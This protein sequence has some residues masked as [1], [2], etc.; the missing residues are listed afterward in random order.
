MPRSHVP[1]RRN[2]VARAARYQDYKPFLREDFNFSCGYCA[3][4]DRFCGGA[5][6]FH[7]DHF[8]P[9][10]P[11]DQ[12]L[13]EYS[14][15]VYSCPFC[16]GGKSN[17][18]IGDDPHV[19]HNGVEGFVDPCSAEFDLHLDRTGDGRFIAL[20]PVGSYMLRHLRL[21]LERH[22]MLWSI[23][24]LELIKRRGREAIR[25]LGRD[26]PRRTPLL[27]Q[28]WEVTNEIDDYLDAVFGAPPED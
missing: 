5:N 7:V 18:W 24:R 8:A 13:L 25:A 23:Q 19:S 1:A 27:V 4:W 6:F 15:L 14:N 9:K 26:D 11:F 17:K 21:Y 28:L 2:G 10:K 3:S 12:L 20:S 22:R 16:N